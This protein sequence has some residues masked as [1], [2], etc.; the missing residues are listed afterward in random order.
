MVSNTYG[1]F[2]TLLR[3]HLKPINMTSF[4][5]RGS[6]RSLAS[7]SRLINSRKSSRSCIRTDVFADTSAT[8][9]K[10]ANKKLEYAL[11]IALAPKTSRNYSGCVK[12]FL[13]FTG[14][15]GLTEVGSLP[16][17]DDLLCLFLAQGIGKTG[18]GTAK[19][20]VSGIRQWHVQRGLPW[21]TSERVALIKKA[22]LQCWPKR[23]TKKA[24]QPPVTHEMVEALA[25]Q[26]AGGSRVELCALAMALAAWNGQMRLGELMPEKSSDTDDSRL[27]ARFEWSLSMSS[28]DA[29]T[30]ELPWTKTTG[31]DGATIYLLKQPHP[32]NASIAIRHHLSASKLAKDRLLCEYEDKKGRPQV[33][34]KAAFMEMCNRV[35]VRGGIG[36]VTGH[37]FHI[38]GTTSFLRAGVDPN[39]VKQM[40]RW[41]SDAFLIYWRALDD[42]FSAH[43]SMINWNGLR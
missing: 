15:I 13:E 29:S 19:G 2:A 32:F 5:T 33:L 6:T 28:L 39:V 1:K 37:S 38:G 20:L 35:W 43:A 42:I 24:Q 25:K 40:G 9:H 18:P 26:W 21:K 41:K 36:R 16:C 11:S 34:D 27:P 10:A 12:R 3:K 30:I 23:G 14:S 4:I 7:A 22:L 31:F 8:R 17:S